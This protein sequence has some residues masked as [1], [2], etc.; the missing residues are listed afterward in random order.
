MTTKDQQTIWFIMV[1]I[2]GQGWCRVGKPCR[3]R[4][5]AKGWL[6]FVKAYWHGLPTRT[7]C[8]RITFGEDGKPDERSRKR[9]DRVF[10]CEVRA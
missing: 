3:R 6:R 8:C 4:D 9:L 10:N 1:D 7:K 5:T 2:P